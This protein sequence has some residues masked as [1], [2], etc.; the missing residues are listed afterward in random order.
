V[1]FCTA[2]CG[3]ALVTG[4]E[5]RPEAVLR[6]ADTAMYRAKEE[7]RDG[8]QLYTR[9]MNATALE[10]LALENGLRKAIGSDEFQV[11]Y[12][13]V[14]DISSGRVHGVEA[15]MRWR[16]PT[17]GLVPP[18]DFIPIAETTGLIASM[19][20][21]LLQ[22][23]CRQAKAWHGTGHAG[24]S[25]AVNLS[26][27]QFR[28]PGLVEQLAQALDES[29]LQPR[30]LELEV[31]ETHLMH[32]AESAA[33]I[34]RELKTLGVRVL[35][36]DFGMGSSS[37]T[38]LKRLPIDAVKIDKSFV[39]DIGT[40]PDDAAVV[41]A[42]V[43]MAHALELAVVAEGVESEE[44]LAFLAARGCDRMQGYLFAHPLPAAECGE[45]LARHASAAKP[46]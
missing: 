3:V 46:A 19:G 5:A 30:F 27:R 22:A 31:S 10:R 8:Y 9:A 28:Q 39:R 37:L 18:S 2:S 1:H 45:L 25:V 41:S 20:P 44:Q 32:D 15:L 29:G 13:P 24:L 7:G 43:A 23:A 6:H 42:A 16:H 21:W 40:D 17:L 11:H 33:R 35:I 34:L 4:G 12:Q 26:S 38:H 36:D 14:L